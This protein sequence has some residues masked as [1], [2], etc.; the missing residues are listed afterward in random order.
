MLNCFRHFYELLYV[1][2][3]LAVL[4][5]IL[6]DM[7]KKHAKDGLCMHPT[8]HPVLYLFSEEPIKVN[9]QNTLLDKRKR[10]TTMQR[11]DV[12]QIDTN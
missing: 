4:F 5:Q 7:Y 10:R 3:A 9:F 6:E 2:K 12:K 1:F 11:E 8:V